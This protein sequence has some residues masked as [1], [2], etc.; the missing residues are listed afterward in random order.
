MFNSSSSPV[1]QEVWSLGGTNR[2]SL[3][4]TGLTQTRELCYDIC[5]VSSLICQQL[6]FL[7]IH[8]IKQ[9]CHGDNVR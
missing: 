6:G 7:L 3:D 1:L 2:R 4:V 5:H 8:L 9:K